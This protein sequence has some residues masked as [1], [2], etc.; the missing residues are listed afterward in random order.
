MA[1]KELYR[2]QLKDLYQPVYISRRQGP[3]TRG[4]LLGDLEGLIARSEQ[5]LYKVQSQST[6][7]GRTY[8][9]GTD[10]ECP[11]TLWDEFRPRVKTF[12]A[13]VGPPGVNALRRLL[14]L[15]FWQPKRLFEPV[16][17]PRDDRP[18]SIEIRMPTAEGLKQ[19]ARLLGIVKADLLRVKARLLG[20]KPAGSVRSKPSPMGRPRDRHINEAL[21]MLR[22]GIRKHKKEHRN[23]RECWQWVFE[24]A[25]VPHFKKEVWPTTVPG[26][27]GTDDQMNHHKKNLRNSLRARG[28]IGVPP[29]KKL[30]TK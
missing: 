23:P 13:D 12:L 25:V 9:E 22:E 24:N 30:R 29:L 26:W 16:A 27:T 7:E 14:G 17:V 15:L 21:R 11:V 20:M 28:G 10:S 19:Y 18:G 4:E 2:P 3:P 6:W 5:L 8:G 1:I